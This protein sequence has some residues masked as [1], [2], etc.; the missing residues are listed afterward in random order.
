MR[1]GIRV[2]A[3]LLLCAPLWGGAIREEGG[4]TVITLKVPSL[5]NAA[6][7]DAELKQYAKR[8]LIDRKVMALGGV[9]LEH[10]PLLKEYGFGGAVLL[11]D[12]WNRFDIHTT[13]DYK[14]LINHFRKLRKAAN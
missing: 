1:N 13:H 3:A 11:G 8:G 12:I 6:F 14:E 5:P 7:T 9:T 2:L 10:I 4:E